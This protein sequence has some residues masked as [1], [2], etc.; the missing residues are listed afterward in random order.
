M[1]ND[2]DIAQGNAIT[3]LNAQENKWEHTK[4]KLHRIP[5][6]IDFYLSVFLLVYRNKHNFIVYV[7]WQFVIF[8]EFSS[9]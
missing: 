3:C 2:K 9:Y 5:V 7:I 4:G 1:R 6:S 8:K